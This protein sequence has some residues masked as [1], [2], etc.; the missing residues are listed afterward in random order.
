CNLWSETFNFHHW[1]EN[2]KLYCLMKI[3][4]M[5]VLTLVLNLWNTLYL[6]IT[7]KNVK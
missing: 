5:V 1:N 4:G 2:K 7:V 6:I 3:M